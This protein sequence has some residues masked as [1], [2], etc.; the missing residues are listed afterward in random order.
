MQLRGKSGAGGAAGAYEEE[1]EGAG[2]AEGEVKDESELAGEGANG[3]DK[4]LTAGMVGASASVS[5]LKSAVDFFLPLPL[6]LCL[7]LHVSLCLGVPVCMLDRSSVPHSACGK[8]F[9]PQV[10]FPANKLNNVHLCLH[11]P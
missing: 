1:P 11:L 9:V 10:L 6:S 2:G 8:Y 3:M 5:V 7:I 4:V